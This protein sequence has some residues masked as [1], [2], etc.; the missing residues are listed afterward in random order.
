MKYPLVIF[1]FDGTL[2]DSFPLFLQVQQ[3]LAQRHGFAPAVGERV[4]A[5]R[6]M[7][8]RE[9]VR[10][11]GV[12]ARRLPIVAADFIRTMRNAPPVPVFPGI[13]DA[14]TLLHGNGVRLAI[15]TSNSADNVPR[16][17]GDGLM[18][19]IEL[20]D[21]GAHILGKHRRISRMLARACVSRSQ[22]IYVGDQTGDGE[23]ARR[24]GVA[25]GAVG[26]GYAHPDVLRA[27]G[28]EEF[29]ATVDELGRMLR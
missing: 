14:L 17:L 11:L 12:S 19:T 18:G 21:G 10:E 7:G 27:L 28:P 24:A 22:A 16:V 23:A 29:F 9:L 1:D 6:M 13:A 5:L 15:L 2:A 4:E 26:W 20:L 8:T 3:E 25:F